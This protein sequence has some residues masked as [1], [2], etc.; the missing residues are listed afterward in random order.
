MLRKSLFFMGIGLLLSWS[1]AAFAQ[2]SGAD[3][4]GNQLLTGQN[5]SKANAG[6]V[7]IMTTRNLGSPFMQMT[8][9]LS[10]LLDAGEHFEDMRVVLM[11]ARG[12]VQN[13]WDIMY[14]K[15]VDAA[16]VQADTL[17]YLK[18]DPRYASKFASVRRN[19]RY[20]AVMPPEEV[21]IVARREIR[22][23]RDLAGKTVSINAKGTGSSVVGTLL[24]ERLK[25]PA[26]LIHLDTRRA[27][28]Q[29]K[30]G[31]IHAHINVLGVPARP[32][33]RVKSEGQLHLLEIP[34]STELGDL[35]VPSKFTSED[36][37]ELVP[38]GQ[39]IR[40]IAARNVLAVY[41]W[42]QDHPRYRKVARFV[43]ALFSRFGELQQKG[44]HPKWKDINL[45][46]TIPGWTR[47]GAAQRWLDENRP[48]AVAS[49]VG[50][51]PTSALSRQETEVR[52][53]LR[54]FLEAQQ[55]REP[56]EAEVNE[57]F[58]QFIQWRDQN[59][60]PGTQ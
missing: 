7:T 49:S 19:V 2:T 13:L 17:E 57:L 30:A 31:E 50:A 38:E 8:L 29:M 59:D 28:A 39:A 16:F 33:A 40:T 26:R 55:R 11:G 18:K 44:Y 23:L 15:G 53:Q 6:T 45:A 20:V 21:H 36:Y 14:L 54:A 48:A 12:K 3:R 58:K 10:T 46:A 42:P 24:F 56:K 32:V 60:S 22:S 9:D 52:E 41:N 1:G 5:A 34:Y 43:E 37:P 35:Y 51:R 47:F 27:I 25:I 4:V